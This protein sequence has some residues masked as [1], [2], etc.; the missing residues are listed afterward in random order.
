[1]S[2]FSLHGKSQ[3]E[4]EAI[5]GQPVKSETAK[6]SGNPVY[7]YKVFDAAILRVEYWDGKADTF[8]FDIPYEWQTKNPEE[9]LKRCGLD[10]SI[11]N[12][13]TDIHGLSWRDKSDDK[14]KTI[15]RLNRIGNG[16]YYNCEAHFF[17]K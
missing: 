2:F 5:Y 8:H 7:H 10:L 4:V 11:A 6:D 13:E 12:A 15:I 9:T 16:D 3:A 1:M 17:T 14:L